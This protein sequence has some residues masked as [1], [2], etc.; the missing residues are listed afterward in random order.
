MLLDPPAGWQPDW[1]SSPFIRKVFDALGEDH[2]RVVGGAVRDSLLGHA[3]ED[4]D[5]ATTHDPRSSQALLETA[6]LKVIPTGLQHGTVTA[7]QG[8]QS[9]EITT[10]RKDVETDGRHA[11]VAFTDSWHEDAARRDFTIN[12]LYATADGRIFDPFNG[13]A[14]LKAG[15]VCFIGNAEERI[16]E[17]A[18]RIYRFFRFSA[19]FACDLD[20]GGLA[21]CR[22]LA[23]TADLLSR[24]RIRDELLKLLN[25]PEPGSFLQ[26]MGE[27]GLLPTI[28]DHEPTMA[29][30]C[31]QFAAEKTNKMQASALLRL[32]SLYSH[33]SVRALARHFRLSNKDEVSIVQL[34]KAESDLENASN[35]NALL[36][37]YGTEIIRE[38]LSLY[39]GEERQ[40][41]L[42]EL[43][44]WQERRFPVSG[45]DLIELGHEPG[46]E[47]GKTLGK[48]ESRWVESDFQLSKSELLQ[49]IDV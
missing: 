43:S 34:R 24:E 38:L 45:R 46:E 16:R 25:L 8:G 3:V 49:L 11:T 36:Y 37:T 21:A 42:E 32:S 29:V 15:R 18:L 14:D 17:D 10:L 26:T 4:V 48:L 41:W 2:V 44:G 13:I 27:I 33:S 23:K 40:R 1:L 5:M 12:A 6:G 47:M 39:R 22:A 35:M 7:V 9:C 30:L 31:E 28:D 19:R 20:E